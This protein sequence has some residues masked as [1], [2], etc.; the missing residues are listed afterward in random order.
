MPSEH[1]LHNRLLTAL[2]DHDWQAIRPHLKEVPL[3]HGDI[4]IRA[5]E[6]IRKVYFPLIG[7][8]SS[9]APF[10]DGSSVEGATIGAEGMVDVGAVLGS[11]TSLGQHV[12]QVPGK[13]LVTNVA[14]FRTW[15]SELPAFQSVLMDYA[16]AF[17]SQVLQS[18][19]CNAVH[20][21]QD[22]AAR[23]LLTC[24]D[25]AGNQPFA[26]TQQFMAEMLGVAR[27]TVNTIARTFQDA[28]LIRYH[29]GLI[30]I[31]DRQGLE[32]ASCECY[33]TIRQAY[34]QRG[35]R[36]RPRHSG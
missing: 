24:D 10:Q 1:Q 28:G 32:A 14:I 16:Q 13:A 26:L 9:V 12:V 29:R 4:L 33:A 25:R 31:L 21:V 23:W 34:E 35:I 8:I 18:V 30:T 3:S 27:P 15:Q 36:L 7:V 6:P 20:P 19:A 5:D 2:P 11:N 22:R 17:V